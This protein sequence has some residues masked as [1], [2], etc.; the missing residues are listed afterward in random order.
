MKEL[1]VH[2]F[3]KSTASSNLIQTKPYLITQAIQSQWRSPWY[4]VT[5]GSTLFYDYEVSK[6]AGNCFYIGI[7]R[8]STGSTS[9]DSCVYQIS[10]IPHAY[11]N[12]RFS[13]SFFPGTISTGVTKY[14]RIRIL[15]NWTGTTASGSAEVY[16]IS[17]KE[18]LPGEN[19]KDIITFTK[20]GT[21]TGFAFETG[22]MVQPENLGNLKCNEIIE[23]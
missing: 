4:A 2:G 13:G 23:Y 19:I 3:E 12:K 16:R 18:Q 11:A 21:V 10:D 14:I 9:N 20:R 7:E 22:S 17:V 6:P 1:N 5:S 8:M 15:S